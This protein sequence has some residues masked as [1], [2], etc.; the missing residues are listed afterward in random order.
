[1]K[2]ANFTSL[3]RTAL[4]EKAARLP[5]DMSI[6]DR[7]Q[8]LQHHLANLVQQDTQKIQADHARVLNQIEHR[9]LLV[10]QTATEQQRLKGI[11]A[12]RTLLAD[13]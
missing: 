11:A 2:A 5:K 3:Y 7:R 4:A 9:R 13:L 1:M 12:T 6:S 8:A 10:H